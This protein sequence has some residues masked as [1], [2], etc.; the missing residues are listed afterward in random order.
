MGR[1][2]QHKDTLAELEGM[3]EQLLGS[4]PAEAEKVL[5]RAL[6]IDPQAPGASRLMA[7]L[8]SRAGAEPAHELDVEIDSVEQN[9]QRFG[10]YFR[11]ALPSSC[12]VA[13]EVR[14]DVKFLCVSAASSKRHSTCCDISKSV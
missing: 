4:D 5:Q 11:L 3:G 12:E 6:E 8:Q 14:G 13:C 7:R 10:D 1:H 2:S 9:S